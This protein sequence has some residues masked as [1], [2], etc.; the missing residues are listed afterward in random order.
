MNSGH[1]SDIIFMKLQIKKKKKE[2]MI[3]NWFG[4]GMVGHPHR[5]ILRVV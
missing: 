1:F 3:K 2:K 4:V 5:S